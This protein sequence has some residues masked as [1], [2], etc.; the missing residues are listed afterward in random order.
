[1]NTKYL[2]RIVTTKRMK[3]QNTDGKQIKNVV[4][5]RKKLLMQITS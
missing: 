3:L 1:M 5:I 2:S 4:G